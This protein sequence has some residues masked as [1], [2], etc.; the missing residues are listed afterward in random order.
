MSVIHVM[1]FDLME[2]IYAVGQPA[3][4]RLDWLMCP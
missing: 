3:K 4:S 1:I 2:R